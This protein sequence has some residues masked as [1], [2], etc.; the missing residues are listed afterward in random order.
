MEGKGETL[1]HND[2]GTGVVLNETQSV[3][4]TGNIFT[5]M[6]RE[7]VKSAGKCERII[8]LGNIF[9]DLT[10]RSEKKFPAIDLPGA[11]DTVVQDN[12]KPAGH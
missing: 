7:A 11:L 3:V 1:W 12:L 10:R 6:S 5:E 4:I 8:V 2:E 9:H